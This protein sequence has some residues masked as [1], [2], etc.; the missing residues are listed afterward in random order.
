MIAIGTVISGTMRSED[1]IPTFVELLIKLD[2]DKEYTSVIEEGWSIMKRAEKKEA[3]WDNE[4]TTEYLNEDLWNALDNFSPDYC[5]FGSHP[6]NGS[7]YGYWPNED[8]EE[9]FDG[10]KV[11]DLSEVPE[12]YKGDHVLLINDHGNVTLYKTVMT[13]KEVWGI[14]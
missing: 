14:V 12:N 4:E 6:G 3:V 1:L 10:L 9:D 8:M 11:S 5:Y 13:L 7:D 2:T